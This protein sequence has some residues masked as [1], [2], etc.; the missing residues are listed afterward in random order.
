MSSYYQTSF[1]L[2]ARIRI[3]YFGNSTKV[4]P[5]INNRLNLLQVGGKLTLEGKKYKIRNIMI[6]QTQG[7]Q[8]SPVEYL[9]CMHLQRK[10]RWS[11]VRIPPG[12]RYIRKSQMISKYSWIRS[13]APAKC[14]CA[15]SFSFRFIHQQLEAQFRIQPTDYESLWLDDELYWFKS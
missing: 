4:S 9:P 8:F 6:N 7:R 10:R 2:N 11:W 5:S 14:N 13:T 3:R 1:N 12:P 15:F